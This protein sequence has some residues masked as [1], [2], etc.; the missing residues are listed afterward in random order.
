[1]AVVTQ[2]DR[3]AGRGLVLTAPPVKR[4]AAALGLPVFQP[5]SINRPESLEHLR[6][7]APDLIVVAAFGQ[8][9]KRQVL[10]L[11]RY[12]CINIHA[13]LLPKYRGAAPIQWAIIRGERWTG[14]TTMIM[15]EGMDTGPILLQRAV[16]IGEDET[17]GELAARLA[18]LGAELVVETVEG[19]LR[20]K[21]RPKPQPAEGTLAPKITEEHT[22]VNWTADARAIHNLVRGLA[23]SPGAYTTFRGKRVKLRRTRPLSEA[24]GAAPG[25]ILP[26]RKRLLVATGDGVLEILSLT[27][28]GRKEIGGVDF[29]NGYRPRPGE[30]F[31]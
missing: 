15:D 8:L 16:R 24:P 1:M 9:L 31:V 20:G 11:P 10:E 22:R 18:E 4:A 27:P 3:P 2:P 6:G 7:L 5:R 17:A 19:Y 25:E 23:P 14:V 13:S 26:H 12:G 30:R 28:E 29:L 21:I